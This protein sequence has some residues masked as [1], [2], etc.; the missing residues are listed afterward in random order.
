MLVGDCL[1]TFLSDRL[2]S[3]RRMRNRYRTVVFIFSGFD[4]GWFVN[5]RL[6]FGLIE[7]KRLNS[8]GFLHFVFLTQLLNLSLKF[9]LILALLVKV[10]VC[11]VIKIYFRPVSVDAL[12]VSLDISIVVDSRSAADL[13]LRSLPLL[14]AHSINTA[15]DVSCATLA[16]NIFFILLLCLFKH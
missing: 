6:N 1:H 3:N 15:G 12:Q 7:D 4:F 9:K 10:Q 14:S 16:I 2:L 13:H 5:W 8:F 11:L